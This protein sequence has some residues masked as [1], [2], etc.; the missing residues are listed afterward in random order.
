[1][2]KVQWKPQTLQP[3]EIQG[4]ATP[5]PLTSKPVSQNFS[6]NT[7][8]SITA[9]PQ[10]QQQ[11][12][13]DMQLQLTIVAAGAD[14]RIDDR[15]NSETPTDNRSVANSFEKNYQPVHLNVSGLLPSVVPVSPYPSLFST[16][17][18]DDEADPSERDDGEWKTVAELLREV[19]HQLTGL[20]SFI[21]HLRADNAVV[22]RDIMQTALR[23]N[24]QRASSGQCDNVDEDDD[25]RQDDD[26]DEDEEEL[27]P[28]RSAPH[29]PQV[30]GNN[31]KHKWFRSGTHQNAGM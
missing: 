25:I 28:L 16:V 3:A 30:T 24:R 1:M 13:H 8:A 17:A 20:R 6:T 7:T 31:E 9:S 19:G 27:R 22:Y 2:K 21:R 11:H 10:Q 12:H 23:L 5:T 18:V 14:A 29:L 15:I 4:L 26:N